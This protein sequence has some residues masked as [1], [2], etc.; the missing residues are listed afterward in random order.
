LSLKSSFIAPATA[1]VHSWA[2][3]GVERFLKL[4]GDGWF[5]HSPFFR[6][7]PK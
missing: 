1:H 7:I 5:D 2:P 4:L 6:A 3:W